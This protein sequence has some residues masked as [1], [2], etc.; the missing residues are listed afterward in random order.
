M[1]NER[2]H[3]KA[4]LAVAIVACTAICLYAANEVT[5]TT[6]LKVSKDNFE[7]TR[8]VA[9]QRY[10]KNGDAT[11][12]AIQSIGTNAHEALSLVADLTTNGWCFMRTVPT[13]QNQ[14]VDVGIQDSNS[15]FLAFLRMK[16]GEMGVFKLNPTATLYAQAGSSTATVTQVDLEFWINQD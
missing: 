8:N 7:L 12:L 4:L 5:V 13:N 2:T 15:V 11:T 9:N 10:D 16:G 6:Y 14:W 1:S 3:L